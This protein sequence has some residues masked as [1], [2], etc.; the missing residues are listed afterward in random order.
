LHPEA[1]VL[2]EEERN[3]GEGVR[4]QATIAERG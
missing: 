3:H 2:D 1:A 4:P